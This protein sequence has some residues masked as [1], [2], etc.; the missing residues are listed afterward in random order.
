MKITK[1]MLDNNHIKKSDDCYVFN[2]SIDKHIDK[3]S[4]NIE[5]SVKLLLIAFVLT[6]FIVFILAPIIVN[7]IANLLVL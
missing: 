2:V 4:D 6:P 1:E 5:I 7:L 3:H